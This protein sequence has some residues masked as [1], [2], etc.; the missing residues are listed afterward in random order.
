MESRNLVSFALS[1]DK[2]IM[3]VDNEGNKMEAGDSKTFL[4][5]IKDE[6]LIHQSAPFGDNK[7]SVKEAL[8]DQ[9]QRNIAIQKFEP[10]IKEASNESASVGIS[11]EELK[12]VS[13]KR[14]H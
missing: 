7:R 10:L 12:K 9:I 5:W 1:E 11:Y 3:L 8:E 6:Q 2:R 13:E 4:R 14:L